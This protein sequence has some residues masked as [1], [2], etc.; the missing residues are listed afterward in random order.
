[1]ARAASGQARALVRAPRPW[2][3]FP[4]SFAADEPVAELLAAARLAPE[5]TF[6]V[7]GRSQNAKINGHDLSTLPPN[8]VLPGFVPVEAFD[9]LL[10]EADVVLALTR[11][12]GVQLSVCNE[13]LGFSRAMVASNT[14]LLRSLFGEAA[15]M[16]DTANP[17]AIVAACKQALAEQLERQE[18]SRAL[19]R[20]RIE[21]W[22]AGPWAELQRLL[23]QNARP[24]TRA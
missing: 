2:I 17:D 20:K 15:V 23:D 21:L 14:V 11:E 12:E 1:M 5:M 24:G 8:V 7:T 19:A 6:I 13:A 4:G 16:A 3:V 9:D 18:L 22:C 10:R